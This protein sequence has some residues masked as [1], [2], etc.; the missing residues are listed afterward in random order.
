M[1]LHTSV[2]FR[3]IKLGVESYKFTPPHAIPPPS[4]PHGP[5]QEIVPVPTLGPMGRVLKKDEDEP[6]RPK[7]L[8][9]IIRLNNRLNPIKDSNKQ[10]ASVESGKQTIG[11]IF[12][13]YFPKARV[14][15]NGFDPAGD[16][17]LRWWVFSGFGALE[18]RRVEEKEAQAEQVGGRFPYFVS[19][20]EFLNSLPVREGLE[21]YG[22]AVYLD[23]QG[24]IIKIKLRGKDFFPSDGKA[25]EVA[26]FA[27]RSTSLVWV[28]I[29]HHLFFSH[30]SVS[31][32]GVLATIQTLPVDNPLRLL[33]KPFLFRTTAINNGGVDSLLPKGSSVHRAAGFTWAGMEEAYT[34]MLRKVALKPLPD[35]LR[36]RGVDGASLSALPDDIFPFGRDSEL[37][38][39]S[40]E[41]F[42]S[43]IF[44]NAPVFRNIEKNDAVK[45]WWAN[46]CQALN[47][48]PKDLSTDQLS[49]FLTQFFFTVSA[50]HS[51]VGH[52]TPYII[53]PSIAAG[54]LFPD[55]TM[56]DQQSSTELG[57][58][59]S[60]TGLPTPSLL[61]DF[62]HL[63]PDAYTR[64]R[65]SNFQ[66]DLLEVGRT[67]QQRNSVRDIPLRA[68]LP[69]E[70]NLSV[71]I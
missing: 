48:S 16:K 66:N 69:E 64:G 4:L 67:I 28:T 32:S 60:I 55:A 54:K 12:G 34:L 3:L 31:N 43:G 52:V 2:F 17:A 47:F 46:M 35:L 8:K 1:N 70:L 59:T 15:W 14:D 11:A 49:D 6:V 19:S 18:L 71:A 68:F 38:W 45:A 63:M 65:L 62:S 41:G 29:Y 57:V 33:L 37:Y 36:E 22:G 5:D 27:Y 24:E 25:W 23:K 58:I 30:Y 42:T 13:N 56:A 9:T 39:R 50:F 61:G 40:L 21:P 53:D 51:W 44:Q 7:I 26:K 10:W 20:Y